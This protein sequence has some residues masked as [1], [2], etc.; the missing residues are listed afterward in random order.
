ML[1]DLSFRGWMLMTDKQELFAIEYIKD[2]HATNAAIRAGY[3]EKTAYSMGSE[4]LK[5]PEIREIIQ[6]NID[7]AMALSRITMKRDVIDELAKEAF[8]SDPEYNPN[9]KLKALELLGKYMTLFTDK[10]EIEHSTVDE[11]GNKAGFKFVDG[12]GK[13]PNA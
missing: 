12:P 3:K 9:V 1:S 2:R 6:A 10:H 13:K 5:K 11:N 4:L 7:E 8:P